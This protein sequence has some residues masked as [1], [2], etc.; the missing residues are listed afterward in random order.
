LLSVKTQE[1]AMLFETVEN[2]RKMLYAKI[3]DLESQ[4]SKIREERDMFRSEGHKK[5]SLMK[6]KLEK[7]FL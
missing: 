2:E 7:A 5:Q 6:E 3:T 4:L 1:T